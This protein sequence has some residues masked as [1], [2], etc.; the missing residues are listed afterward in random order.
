MALRGTNLGFY[1]NKNEWLFRN[2]N[3]ELSYGEI[4]GIS[5]YSGSGKT[6]L[7]RILA[8]Y[9]EPIEGSVEIDEKRAA[10]GEAQPIQLIYQHPEK[11]I[12]PKWKMKEVLEESYEPDDAILERFGIRKE[13]L[14]RYPIELSGGELQRFCIVRALHPNTKYII[15]DEISTMLDAVTQTVIWRELLDICKERKIGVAIIS[16]EAAL[17]SRLCDRI[18]SLDVSAKKIGA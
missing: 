17:I 2:L 4:L 18:I 8:N 7:S 12:N 1:Y 16:H 5:G 14:S 6:S 10:K 9:I 3:I 15:A 13:W 11:A